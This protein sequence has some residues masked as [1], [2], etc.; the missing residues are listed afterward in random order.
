[1]IQI[2]RVSDPVTQ[3]ALN[4]VKGYLQRVPRVQFVTVTANA[5]ADTPF[6]VAHS[7]GV[8]PVC[9]TAMPDVEAVV[10]ATSDDRK[11]WS[12]SQ[13]KIRCT[14]A[15]ALLTVRVEA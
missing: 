13:I 2:P 12:T 4:T 1:L 11:E 9:A 5:T 7:L 14:A 8:V 15:S 3:N 6:I 10:Y